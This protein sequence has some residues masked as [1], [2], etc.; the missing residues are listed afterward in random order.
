M[1]IFRKRYWYSSLWVVLGF[2][3]KDLCW[4]V[5]VVV[6]VVM[7]AAVLS[8]LFSFCDQYSFH[9]PLATRYSGLRL[10]ALIG[11]CVPFR[12]VVR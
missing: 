8:F 7:M 11:S 4:V 5:V 9:S 2:Y 1:L 10:I 12:R 6:V 3:M